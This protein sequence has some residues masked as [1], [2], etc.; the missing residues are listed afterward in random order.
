[1]HT[2][3]SNE[4]GIEDCST[5]KKRRAVDDYIFVTPDI[6]PI[7]ILVEILNKTNHCAQ[8]LDN[9][10]RGN[11]KMSSQFTVSPNEHFATLDNVYQLTPSVKANNLHV[12]TINMRRRAV[13]YTIDSDFQ[14]NYVKNEGTS[15]PI[16]GVIRILAGAHTIFDIAQQFLITGLTYSQ[17]T[18]CFAVEPAVETEFTVTDEKSLKWMQSILGIEAPPLTNGI[19]VVTVNL[20]TVFTP[21]TLNETGLSATLYFEFLTDR[22]LK[23]NQN[24]SGSWNMGSSRYQVQMDKTNSGLYYSAIGLPLSIANKQMGDYE[25][26]AVKA[27]FDTGRDKVSGDFDMSDIYF[28]INNN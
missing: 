23:A 11:N 27:V 19:S 4:S 6:N 25:A 13:D 15:N 21:T 17:L 24:V 14:I 18:K 9:L 20:S 12:N 28:T 3:P 7:N 1:M 10:S 8:I 16:A 26:I 2:T 22:E 5:S